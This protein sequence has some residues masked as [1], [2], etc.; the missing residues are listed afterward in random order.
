MIQNVLEE[1][2]QSP[3]N[4]NTQPWQVHIVSGAKRDELATALKAADDAGQFTPD[5]YFDMTEYPQL[6]AERAQSS[7]KARYDAIK[8]T[9]EDREGRAKAMRLNLDFFG[10]PH[11]A[12]LFMPA[13]GDSVRVASDMGMYGQTFLLSLTAHGLAG[14]PQTLLGMYADTVREVLGIDSGMKMLFGISFGYADRTATAN[15]MVV[16]RIPVSQSVTF[17]G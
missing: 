15:D 11:V 5:Y 10:A 3:S 17:H 9:R 2:Q 16:G 13:L 4:C 12:L 6:Y 8:V 14:I 7:A 1:A